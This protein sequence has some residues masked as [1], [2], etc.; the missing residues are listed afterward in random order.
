MTLRGSLHKGSN[1][2]KDSSRSRLGRM[3]RVQSSAILRPLLLRGLAALGN[4]KPKDPSLWRIRSRQVNSL[5]K[6][7]ID[8][9]DAI[10]DRPKGAPV[11]PVLR[12]KMVEEVIH[13]ASSRARYCRASIYRI[14]RSLATC[15]LFHRTSGLYREAGASDRKPSSGAYRRILL[16]YAYFVVAS[17]AL[18]GATGVDEC[19]SAASSQGRDVL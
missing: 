15:M 1:R 3:V 14:R 17:R 7:L 4:G 11:P 2:S 12:R 10:P 13:F 8:R 9:R 5:E 6:C 16:G 19:C 18:L